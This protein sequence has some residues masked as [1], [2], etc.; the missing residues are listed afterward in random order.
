M[1]LLERLTS[2]VVRL[3]TS[4]VVVTMD[5]SGDDDSR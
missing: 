5:G 1:V 3:H 4:I 2:V